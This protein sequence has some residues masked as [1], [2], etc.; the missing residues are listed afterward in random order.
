M[1]A[2]IVN[3]PPDFERRPG[4]IYLSAE[5]YLNLSLF[6]KLKRKPS[7]D[8]FPG[9][10]IL[11]RYTE[12]EEIYRQGEAGWT[13][14]YALTTE[15]VLGLREARHLTLMEVARRLHSKSPNAYARYEQGKSVPTVE[16]LNQ[17]LKAIDPGCEPI[18]KTG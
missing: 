3:P 10:L 8:K 12:G 11:R 18:L 9:A 5:Q 13:A 1:A 2:Q 16:K 15:D 6:A 4:D 14:F 17:L 7:L